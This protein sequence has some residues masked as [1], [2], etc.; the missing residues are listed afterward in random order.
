MLKITF[1]QPP[2]EA[3]GAYSDVD[4]REQ[5]WIPHG[6]LCV[7]AILDEDI[8][9]TKLVDGRL[10]SD[11]G[12]ALVEKEMETSTV[13]ACSVMTGNAIRWALRASQI[14]KSHDVP[15][16]WGGPHPT[17][18]PEQ[19]LAHPLVDFV[20]CGGRGEEPF[21]NWAKAFAVGDS[22][23]STPGLG[24]KRNGLAIVN[25][26]DHSIRVPPRDSLP[27]PKFDLIQKFDP[28]VL[29]DP[30]IAPRTTNHVTSVGCPYSCNFC[31]EPA[32]S[33]R[34]W[35]SW[36]AE[37]SSLEVERLVRLCH[38]SG[39]K[40]HDALF[41]VDMNR[42][43]EFSR[44]IKQIGI[45]WGATMH[46]TALLRVKDSDLAVLRDSG[47]SRLM[48][49]LESGNQLVINMV[50]K[51]YDTTK[52]PELACKLRDADIIG[53][54]SFVVGFPSVPSEEY[55]DTI[56]AAHTIHG[57]W[58]QH[59]VKI[60]Y[61]SPWPGTEL[62]SIAASIPGF[63]APRTLS[64]WADYDY[65]VAQFCFQDKK[66]EREITEINR[67]YCPYYHA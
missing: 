19:T 67:R 13:L 57:I 27:S 51:H 39:V 33:G 62:W 15:T 58:N 65:Y 38:V 29:N 60:H 44:S 5:T 53:M 55:R 11:G 14:A 17:L 3:S 1:Y 6:I 26:V 16:L 7:A 46:P 21:A 28:Y 37:R 25:P 56:D 48:V 10:S 31:S 35:H 34:R 2:T 66:W 47:L 61:A 42:A 43:I 52:I 9:E 50:G 18:F 41:F 49:G 23:M 8:W 64:E 54:F 4:G 36:S 32:L 45:R 12:I 40:L 63:S 30:A 22:L 20:I 24:H 59:Q